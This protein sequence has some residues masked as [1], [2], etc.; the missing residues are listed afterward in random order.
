MRTFIAIPIEDPLRA[1]LQAYVA[2]WRSGASRAVRWVSPEQLHITLAFLG[3]LTPERVLGSNGRP[4]VLSAVRAAAQGIA[5]FTCRLGGRGAFPERGGPRVLWVGWEPAEPLERLAEAVRT[6]LSRLSL[7]FDARPFRAHVTLGRVRGEL[8]AAWLSAWSGAE[9]RRGH[10]AAPPLR[11]H[12]IATYESRLRRGGPEYDIVDRAPL[13]PAPSA[14]S[15]ASNA[16]EGR[17]P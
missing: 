16:K 5:P 14:P 3:E 15:A 7:P 12:E 17:Q 13:S 10:E 1:Y 4:G 6:E 9:G 8:T 11:V 2:S